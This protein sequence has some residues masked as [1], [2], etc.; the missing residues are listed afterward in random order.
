[1]ATCPN[2]GT[3]LVTSLEVEHDLDEDGHP[4]VVTPT[5][6]IL[7]CPKCFMAVD[8]NADNAPAEVVAES[9]PAPET[10]GAAEAEPEAQQ[11]FA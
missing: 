1:M 8:P 3:T 10:E 2:D 9:G 7:I 11:P 6:G 4:K 5:G